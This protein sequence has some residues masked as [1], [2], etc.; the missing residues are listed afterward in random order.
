MKYLYKYPQ[1]EFPYT[2]LLRTNRNRSRDAAEAAF[3]KCDAEAK[4]S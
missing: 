2:D 4:A 3:R 1:A